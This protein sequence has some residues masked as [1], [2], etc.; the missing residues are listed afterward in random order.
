MSPAAASA[1][2][3]VEPRIDPLEVREPGGAG[4]VDEDVQRPQFVLDALDRGV[5]GGAVRD[6]GLHREPAAGERGRELGAFQVD[7]HHRD[8]GAL[9]GQAHADRLADSGRAAGDRRHPSL[10]PHSASPP[11]GTATTRPRT[12]P[13]SSRP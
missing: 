9:S 10:E 1:R 4:V 6:V 7:V 3:R 2:W 8:A 13:R 5:D 12:S 11:S